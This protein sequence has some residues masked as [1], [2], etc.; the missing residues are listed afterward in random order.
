MT[1]ALISRGF[2]YKLKK[3]YNEVRYLGQYF[4]LL[5]VTVFHGFRLR[6]IT[7]HIF[8]PEFPIVEITIATS[9]Q[10][11]ARPN[12]QKHRA[13]DFTTLPII[14][15]YIYNIQYNNQFLVVSFELSLCQKIIT[16]SDAL[17]FHR[18]CRSFVC[19]VQQLEPG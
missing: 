19:T 5:R 13:L 18:I 1:I 14:I 6:P 15:I 4:L 10:I 16:V 17:V 7:M 12:E 2:D 9:L 8:A 3:N 11:N